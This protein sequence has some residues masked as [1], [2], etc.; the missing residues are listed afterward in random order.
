[1]AFTSSD[2]TAHIRHTAVA[3]ALFSLL[4]GAWIAV[5]V[6]AQTPLTSIENGNGEL[7]LQLNYDGGFHVPGNYAGAEASGDSIP[8][9]GAGYHIIR[10]P[11]PSAGIESFAALAVYVPGARRL[12]LW[13]TSRVV[14][15]V[16]SPLRIELTAV[17]CWAQASPGP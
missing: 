11:A 3:V 12:P 16:D 7:R 1:M 2:P 5:P 8:A 15:G 10:V 6:E 17:G 4:S 13:L 9:T 14:S